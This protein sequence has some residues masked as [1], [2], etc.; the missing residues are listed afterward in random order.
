MMSIWTSS[1]RMI[2]FFYFHGKLCIPVGE[3]M[4][5]WSMFPIYPRWGKLNEYDLIL[6]LF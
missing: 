1:P 2:T 6:F 4:V 3:W 5:G